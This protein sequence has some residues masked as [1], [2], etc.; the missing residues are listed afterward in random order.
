MLVTFLNTFLL[1]MPG[2]SEWILILLVVLLFFGGKKIPDLM[3]GIGRGV[4]EFNDAKTNVKNEI[5]AGMT[6]K[7]R[8]EQDAELELRQAQERLQQAQAKVEQAKL[9]QQ[10][11]YQTELPK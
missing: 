9:A 11:Q 7:D 10:A 4:R 6:E 5:E 1:S 2:G 8:K 3:R